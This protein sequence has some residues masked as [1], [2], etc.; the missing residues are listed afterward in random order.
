MTKCNNGVGDDAVFE[1]AVAAEDG[2]RRHL[3]QHH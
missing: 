2:G 1:A 3:S